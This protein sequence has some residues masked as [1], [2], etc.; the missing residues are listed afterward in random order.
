M[1]EQENILPVFES[2]IPCNCEGVIASNFSPPSANEERNNVG[3][4]FCPS[5]WLTLPIPYLTY[6]SD[7]QNEVHN[8]IIKIFAPRLLNGTLLA[9]VLSHVAKEMFLVFDLGV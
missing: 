2:S 1:F 6:T 8:I 3:I 7:T 4:D 5:R 9:C